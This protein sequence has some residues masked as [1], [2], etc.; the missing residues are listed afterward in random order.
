MSIPSRAVYRTRQFLGALNPAVEAS[1]VEQARQLLGDS[2][3][4][5]F[6]SMSRRDQR[7]CLDVYRG[8]VYT[9]CRD[10]H[11]LSAALLHDAG[12]GSLAGDRVRLHHRVTYVV[13][14]AAAPRL[15]GP[16]ARGRGGLATLHH[17]AERGAALA[18]AHGAPE[19]VVAL[20][21]NHETPAAGDERL[22]LLRA[23]DDSC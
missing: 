18:A 10:Q 5:L 16:L 23:A 14:N 22:R 7:H 20:I 6:L 1:E 9:S 11:V 19:A 15:L 2:L 13:L 8:L 3:M 12:K 4:P 17:H 21:H